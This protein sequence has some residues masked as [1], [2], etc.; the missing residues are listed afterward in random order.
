[1]KT[2]CLLLLL[3]IILNIEFFPQSN[4][5][6]KFPDFRRQLSK[7]PGEVVISYGLNEPSTL[8]RIGRLENTVYRG[9]YQWNLSDLDIPDYSVINYVKVS[10]NYFEQASLQV[11]FYNISNDMISGNFLNEIWEEM[12]YTAPN[13][14]AIGVEASPVIYESSNPEAAFNQAIRNSLL[15]D[16]FVL[17]IKWSNDHFQ[18]PNSWMIYNN[19]LT[20]QIVFTPPNQIVTI[21]QRNSRNEQIGVLRK[22]EGAGF[23]HPPFSPGTQFIFPQGVKQTILGDPQIIQNEK[24]NNWNGLPDV[25]N[26]HEFIINSEINYLTSYFTPAYSGVSL[27]NALEGTSV[28]GGYLFFKDPWFRDF[29]DPAYDD[30]IRNRGMEGAEF[31]LRNSPFY[32]DY[33][34]SFDNNYVYQGIFLNEGS[35]NWSPPYYSLKAEPQLI[36]LSGNRGTRLFNFYKWNSPNGASFQAPLTDETP[37]VFTSGNATVEAVMKGNLM[38]NQTN[39]LNTSQ[40]KFVRLDDEIY[41]TIYES[42]NRIWHTSSSEGFDG[43]WNSERDLLRVIANYYDINPSGIAANPSFDVYEDKIYL[44]FEYKESAGAQTEIC[45]TVLSNDGSVA[46]NLYKIEN[47][48]PSSFFG[49]AKPVIACFDIGS[50]Y[51]EEIIIYYKRTPNEGYYFKQWAF[52]S[53]YDWIGGT[54][55]NTSAATVDLSIAP[56]RNTATHDLHFTHHDLLSVKYGMTTKPKRN[57]TDGYYIVSSGSSLEKNIYPS[58]SLTGS[59]NTVVVSWKGYNGAALPKEVAGGEYPHKMVTRVKQNGTWGDFFIAGDNVS[60]VNNNSVSSSSPATVIAWSE[61]NGANAKWIKRVGTTYCNLSPLSHTGAVP[62]VS[63]ATGLENIEVMVLNRSQLPYVIDRCTNN[64]NIACDYG[65]GGDTKMGK[66]TDVNSIT[67]GRS[68][69]II[70]NGI[71]FVFNI[72]D[73]VNGDSAMNF[74]PMP[75]TITWS[76]DEEI[77]NAVRTDN[78]QLNQSSSFLFSN[79]Y[80]V[81]H[82]EAADTGLTDLDR[83]SF[84]AE[85]VNASTGNVAG[86]FDEISYDKNNLEKYNNISYQVNCSGIPEGEYYLRLVTSTQGLCSYNLTNVQNYASALQKRSFTEIYYDGSELPEE[87]QLSQNYPNPFNP[88]T[89]INFHLPQDGFITLKLYDILGKEVTTLA[90]GYKNRGRYSVSFDASNLASGMYIY[91]LQAGDFVSSKKM[92]LIK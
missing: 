24:Y 80:Y 37:V 72:G 54:L 43:T 87:Y 60:L 73:V 45:Y 26:Y 59:D 85:L 15:N 51:N 18:Y 52:N 21:D 90:E 39:A 63:N 1:M 83:V 57:L 23:S 8:Y 74:I 86:V 64:F 11:N 30:I 40:K 14:G 70:K 41:V 27:R 46:Y 53:G 5:G 3:L 84:R 47:S 81:L 17:G 77:N 16:K 89:T 82:K 9:V 29:E 56:A 31:R 66:I 36:D 88:S 67:Y 33:T 35:P 42:M 62:V 28:T 4:L 79:Y 58:I 76:S 50:A 69:V 22:W 75:D 55:T 7:A 61:N 34:T 12:N 38:S 91:R 10:F 6:P 48:L 78:F 68:G 20:L 2:K 71:E 19:S 32:P 65:G 44:T 13:I 25:T 49:Q 92:T